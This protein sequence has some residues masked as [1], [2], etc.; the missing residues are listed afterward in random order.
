MTQRKPLKTRKLILLAIIVGV[1]SGIGAF[2]FYTLLEISTKFFI[3]GLGGYNPYP[4]GGD[5]E[6]TKFAFKLPKL[7]I[8][9][10]PA[11]G[12]LISGFI[13]YRFA[14]EAEGHGTDAVIKAFHR[15]KGNVRGRVPIVKTIASA[16]TIGSGGS[17]G[18]EGP[19][20]QIGAGF[21]SFLGNLLNL[22]DRDR[23]IL[24]LCGVSGGIGSIFQSPMGGA[25]FGIEVLYRRDYEVEALVPSFTSS[26]VA[27]TVYN[28]LLGFT[29][30]IHFGT[31]R[32]FSTPAVRIN[33][34]ADLLI[35]LVIAVFAGIIGLI[36]IKAF[37]T[38]HEY[39]KKVRIPNYF[40]PMIGGLL[41][42]L[43][44]IYI[45]EAMGMGYGIVQLAIDGKIL[46]IYGNLTL[47][48]IF[49][50]IFAKILATSFTI[51]SGGSGGVFAPSVVIGGM[52]GAF[53][54]Y[55]FQSFGVVEEPAFFVL[56]GMASFVSAVAKTP[57][58]SIIMVLEMTGGYNLLPAL[59]ISSILAYKITGDNSIYSEQ[60]PTRVD[61]PVHRAEM[62]IDVLE[63]VKVGDAMVPAEK[64]VTVTP[65][66]K[67]IE[68]MKMIEETGHM[69]YPVM[70][71]GKIVGIITFE[72]VERV[73]FEERNVKTV[74]DVM[75]KDIIATY[76][77]ETLEDALKK[78]ASRNIGRLPVLSRDDSKL[79]GLIT[80]SD[81][82]RAHAKEVLRLER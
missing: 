6:I 14:P 4:A 80:R 81:I 67:L 5:I 2:V 43:I 72:D 31:L 50:F 11:I 37:Y 66:M 20:A 45:P 79:V 28:L 48:F 56:V 40:K 8:F 1:I 42:G 35:C 18:R 53:V 49:I 69:G 13:V 62:V 51:G 26:I 3:Q 22:S 24:L 9:L 25:L 41:T 76:P 12:G 34:P 10:I 23:R 78:L 57:I 15:L 17:A 36:Y 32:I 74:A 65:E 16:I 38:T 58:A 73:P 64:V 75:T 60:V 39:F 54:G 55:A 59:M 70:E 29:N 71:N 61:S 52:I 30:Q 82:M 77:D 7:P 68:V 63:N 44:A 47:L 33:S 19:I 21:G 27:Y 46:S